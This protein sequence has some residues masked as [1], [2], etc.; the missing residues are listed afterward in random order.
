MGQSNGDRIWI[1]QVISDL[2]PAEIAGELPELVAKGGAG[3]RFAYEEFF[4][5]RLRNPHTRKAYPF[6]VHEFLGRCEQLGI[7][8]PQG[9]AT[10]YQP[11]PRQPRLLALD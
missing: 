2:Q 6:A 1:G 3:A 4:Y 7:D 10:T 9:L 5:G 8:L 11:V